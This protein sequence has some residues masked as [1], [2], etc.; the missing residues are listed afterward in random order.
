[1][2]QSPDGG[3]KVHGH[4]TIEVRDPDGTLVERR[5][6]D[7]AIT[8]EGEMILTRILGRVE[9]VGNWQIYTLSPPASEVC[10][11]PV[12]T[13]HGNCHIA[14]AGDPTGGANNFFETLSLSL[15]SAPDPYSLNLSGYLIAQR[16]GSIYSV[17]TVVYTCESAI[18]PDLCVG[19]GGSAFGVT[20]TTLPSPVPALTGQQVLV[21]VVISF[22]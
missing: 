17:Y 22:S 5:E 13:P 20:D 2:V 12:A 16:D 4:W 7:N 1:M 11:A 15:S 9:T 10:E 3:I 21:T 14:E 18:S 8:G 6:F 19:A